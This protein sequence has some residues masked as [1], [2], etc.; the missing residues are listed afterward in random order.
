MLGDDAHFF[1]I[2]IYNVQ[3]KDVL[4]RVHWLRGGGGESFPKPCS[5][6]W[7]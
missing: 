5:L 4:L 6:L 3:N 7:K 1:G 2:S